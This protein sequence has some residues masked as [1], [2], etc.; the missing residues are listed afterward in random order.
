VVVKVDAGVTRMFEHFPEDE[1]MRT[2][3]LA[4]SNQQVQVWAT[5]F[6]APEMRQ[7]VGWKRSLGKKE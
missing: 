4:Y 5:D 3:L 6:G 1:T 2:Y 7:H